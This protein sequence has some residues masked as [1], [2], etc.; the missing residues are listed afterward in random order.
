MERCEFIIQNENQL[1]QCKGKQQKKYGSY[2]NK[3]KRNYL[4]DE[5]NLLITD[6]FTFSIKDYLIKDLMNYYY[7]KIKDEKLKQKYKKQF[8]FDKISEFIIKLNQYKDNQSIIKIQRLYRNKN[9]CKYNRCKNTEDFYTFDPLPEINNKYFYSYKDLNNLYWGFDIRSLIKVINLNTKNPYTTEDI[10]ENIVKEV[11]NKIKLLEKE[12]DYKGIEEIVL[13][14]RKESIKQNAV[15]LFSDIEFNGYSC[16]LSWFFDLSGR[17]LKELYKQLEDIW[18]YRA[19]LT[20]DS[21]KNMCPP[22]GNIF[23]TP[24]NEVYSYNCKEDLQELILHN[25]SKFKNAL[26]LSDR[27]LGYMYF[28]IGLSMVSQDCY[29][30]HPW[31]S[32][33]Q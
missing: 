7:L 31:V 6:R 25:I 17:R 5:N 15:D 2:C 10:P 14:D 1:I 28:I 26:S 21:K 3:H 11:K 27:R 22:D 23:T 19:Q 29:L 16:Q 32:Y 4:I 24:I 18:N 33:I 12:K 13:K 20:N 9:R 8:Y 30:T